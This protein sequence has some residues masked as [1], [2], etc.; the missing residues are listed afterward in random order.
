MATD[1]RCRSDNQPVIKQHFMH[2]PLELLFLYSLLLLF[3]LSLRSSSLSFPPPVLPLPSFLFSSFPPLPPSSSPPSSPLPPPLPFSE[4]ARGSPNLRAEESVLVKPS[5]EVVALLSGCDPAVGLNANTT[6]PP[7][8]ITCERRFC[9]VLV[10]CS[11]DWPCGNVRW[12][13]F[14]REEIG[15]RVRA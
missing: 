6:G 11:T 14:I 4:Y 1:H 10:L 2:R 5:K 13:P 3:S 8:E 9:L 12:N 15:V 7:C